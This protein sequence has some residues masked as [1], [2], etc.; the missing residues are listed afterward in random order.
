M[1]K[2]ELLS[3]LKG[4]SDVVLE[5]G[6]GEMEIEPQMSIIMKRD[7]SDYRIKLSGCAVKYCGKTKTVK[8]E[9]LLKFIEKHGAAEGNSVKLIGIGSERKSFEEY[10]ADVDFSKIDMGGLLD[11]YGDIANTFSLSCPYDGCG[12]E[13]YYLSEEL[14]EIAK[15]EITVWSRETAKKQVEK[16]S[17]L[18]PFEKLYKEIKEE[19]L[20]LY[21]EKEEFARKH[22]GNIFFCDEFANGNAKYKTPPE[23]WHV[24][25]NVEFAAMCVRELEKR[26]SFEKTRDL[27]AELKA[28]GADGVLIQNLNDIKVSYLNHCTVGGCL[29]KTFYFTLNDDTKKWLL[30]HKDDYD[31]T[32]LQDLAFYNGDDILFSSCTHEGFHTDLTK[33]GEDK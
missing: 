7:G 32:T 29:S 4:F 11:K 2:E 14:A 8:P 3:V 28:D 13:T 12:G 27:C 23:L 21:G 20:A 26:K 10:L 15:N 25:H 18:P 17:G 6:K 19:Y 30:R 1:T 33:K 9:K 31:F 5:A 24:Y 16:L 22:G